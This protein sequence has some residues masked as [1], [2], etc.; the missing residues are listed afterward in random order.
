MKGT[1]FAIIL[2][3]LNS[4]YW[5]RPLGMSLV[6]V[7]VAG[8]LYYLDQSIPN[9]IQYERW[10]LLK[11]NVQQTRSFLTLIVTS[12]LGVL[13]IVFSMTL[14]VLTMAASQF[15]SFLLRAFMRDTRTQLVLAMYCATITYCITVLLLMPSTAGEDMVP[16]ISGTFA[17]LLLVGSLI[18]LIF[19]FNHV[20]SSF[21]AA[22]VVAVV[23]R[24]LAA[25]INVELG[26]TQTAQEEGGELV[27]SRRRSIRLEG[28]PV[29]AAGS[30]YI[31]AIDYDGLAR[32]ASRQG[33]VFLITR[34]PG[35]FVIAGEPLLLAWPPGKIDSSILS[36]EANRLCMLG[37]NRT[38]LQDPLFGIGQLT[39]IASRALSP[40][41]NDPVTANM[42]VDRLG[43]ALA[44]IAAHR[45]RMVY[46][47]DDRKELR[48]IA[49]SYN[50]DLLVGSAFN[51][52]RQYGRGTAEV[53]Q[54][55]LAAIQSIAL[56]CRTDTQ[57]QVLLMHARLIEAE[58]RTGL[59]S[60][61]D[62]ERVRRSFEKTV[63]DI[64][65]PI[66]ADTR[67]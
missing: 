30:G 45:E 50:F 27:E 22:R 52:I 37:E 5:F 6:A 21:Q 12:L 47:Y 61:Y 9:S 15:G 62:R 56:F 24:E 26:T 18:M 19:F 55:M 44:R 64:G 63:Q 60:E 29:T 17:M 43:E 14:V 49:E 28:T 66:T 11:G 46:R 32:S 36:P 38:M 1:R 2:D 51:L 23:G 25:T 33:L 10:F 3:R 58:S 8:A 20:A 53:L 35:D 59:P 41:I 48:V 34:M 54:R 39:A 7:A 4:S 40:A 57:R 67:T 13:G 16:L 65:L 42:C 31:T